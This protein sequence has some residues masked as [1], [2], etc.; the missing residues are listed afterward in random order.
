MNIIP[1]DGRPPRLFRRVLSV[2]L[3]A[4]D[5]VAVYEHKSNTLRINNQLWEGLT[6]TQRHFV[7]RT[8]SPI[9]TLGDV[10]W[11]RIY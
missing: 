10:A 7:E 11:A 2:E 8:T 3:P 5:V 1:T 4:A 6:P 9:T